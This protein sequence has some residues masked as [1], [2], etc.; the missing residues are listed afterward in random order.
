MSSKYLHEA[1]DEAKQ[2]SIIPLRDVDLNIP[3]ETGANS[4]TTNLLDPDCISP[5]EINKDLENS[6]Y[7]SQPV[8]PEEM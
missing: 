6:N 5:F 1:V 2:I 3:V 8:V 4:A 7:N